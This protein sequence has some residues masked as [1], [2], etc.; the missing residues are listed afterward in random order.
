MNRVKTAVIFIIA[1]GALCFIWTEDFSFKIVKSAKLVAEN[2]YGTTHWDNPVDRGR[3]FYCEPDIL[4]EGFEDKIRLIK[5]P[6]ME[7]ITL[8]VPLKDFFTANSGLLVEGALYSTLKNGK[9]RKN[10]WIEDCYYYDT[11]NGEAGLRV[12][13]YFLMKKGSL[14][15]IYFVHWDLN[16]N[17]ITGAVLLYE[18]RH[19]P[20]TGEY[21]YTSVSVHPVG[22]NHST[23]TYYFIKNAA[24]IQVKKEGK[25][26]KYIHTKDDSFQFYAAKG[27][28]VTPVTTIETG[29]WNSAGIYN[30]D[31]NLFFLS[32]YKDRGEVLD[33]MNP[34]G[35][36]VNLTSG[37]Y[38]QI[39]I[40]RN[41]YWCDFNPAKNVLYHASCLTGKLWATDLAT[42]A[43]TAELYLGDAGDDRYRKLAVRDENTLLYYL[44]GTLFLVD[45]NTY[46]ILNTVSLPKRFPDFTTSSPAYILPD[47]RGVIMEARTDNNKTTGFLY[48]IR[49]E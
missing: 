45:T 38:K 42:G 36:L 1:A 11:Q 33:R 49:E 21:A 18:D 37:T 2:T 43:K 19:I 26:N 47:G 39:A 10:Y 7:K 9:E 35:F 12:I 44:N 32:A 48:Y 46:K 8:D 25:Y 29:S 27:I 23:K 34:I 13:N 20:R 40:Q 6:E 31:L 41:T 17:S 16:T 15:R 22:Y 3:M 30:P 24:D 28:N 14:Q 5:I 4:N